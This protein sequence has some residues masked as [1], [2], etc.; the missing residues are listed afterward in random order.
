MHPL[1][2]AV[3]A[4]GTAEELTANIEHACALPNVIPLQMAPC[5]H[6]GDLII[7]GSGPSLGDYIE[8]LKELQGQ[9]QPIMAVKGA[10]DYLRGRGVTPDMFIS[11][12]PRF[13]PVNNPSKDTAFLLASRCHPD[14]F[15]QLEGQCI[16]LWHSWTEQSG[17]QALPSQTYMIG[18]GTTSG[19]RAINVGYTLGFRNFVLF[20]FDCCLGPEGNKRVTDEKL[21][22]GVETIPVT[23]GEKT[24]TCT[25]AMAQQANE[26]QEIYKVMGDIHIRASGGLFEAIL[27]ERNRAGFRT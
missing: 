9:G 14:L 12:E 20:G 2:I 23:V 6:A 21:A 25:M 5:K 15:K 1:E 3:K 19:L 27:E 16:Y 18:G 10:Y 26:F 8:L 11:V 22:D 17:E 4:Y 7:C 13:R 24:F